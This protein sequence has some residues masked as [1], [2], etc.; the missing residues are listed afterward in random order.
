MDV[1]RTVPTE[2]QAQPRGATCGALLGLERRRSSSSASSGASAPREPCGRGP[3]ASGG[4]KW[5]A[6]ASRCASALSLPASRSS[7]DRR[8]TA[9]S[10][11]PAP[12]SPAGRQRRLDLAPPDGQ[13]VG[14]PL[15]RHRLA[16]G[17]LVSW[18]SH[19]PGDGRPRPVPRRLPRQHPEPQLA[20]AT[21]GASV[22]AGR[23]PCP[24]WGG[25]QGPPRQ[26]RP[27]P[28]R[29]AAHRSTGCSSDGE[30]SSMYP[31]WTVSVPFER[32]VP[33]PRG[34][35]LNR[36]CGQK[37][38]GAA[39]RTGRPSPRHAE[40]RHLSHHAPSARGGLR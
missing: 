25:T 10:R 12:G 16:H 32:G 29:S 38:A 36:R 3:A 1:G 15:C 39:V 7:G 19:T 8:A 40:D 9:R 33:R 11:G 5:P 4:S 37:V 18:A 13:G 23:P 30:A 21:R 14:E 35:C 34:P 31:C 6:S 22:A 17:R 28:L 24:S 20:A 2:P 27:A 26:R